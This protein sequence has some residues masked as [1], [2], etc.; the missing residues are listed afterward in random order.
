MSEFVTRDVEVQALPLG[1]VSLLHPER[2]VISFGGNTLDIGALCYRRLSNARRKG[3][4]KSR[5]VDPCSLDRTRI[6]TVRR[7]INCIS[8]IARTSGMS[9]STVFT[10]TSI[11]IRFVDWCATVG[12]KGVFGTE[13]ETRNAFRAYVEHLRHRVST[14]VLN[15]HT[16]FAY[17][18]NVL[19]FLCAFLA[20]DDIAHGVRLLLKGNTSNPTLVPDEASQG[21]VLSLCQNFFSQF[22]THVH[23]HNT[24]PFKLLLPDYL[25]WADNS[26]WIF[27][28]NKLFLSP[29]KLR[30]RDNMKRGYWAV[31]YA[32]GR[33]ATLDEIGTKY[34]NIGNAKRSIRR[35]KQ[36]ITD[37]NRDPKHGHRREIAMF[38]H[39]AFVMLFIANT[40]MNWSEVRKLP[41]GKDYEVGDERQGFRA[42]KF[43]AKGKS[44]S[45]EIQT[46]FL[47]KF[48]R[49]LELRTYLVNGKK[50]DTLF[51]SLGLRAK[52]KPK[53]MRPEVLGTLV[54]TLRRIDPSLPRILSRQ[55]RAAKSDFL[56]T[57]TDPSTTALIL[58]NSEPT[59]LR[60]YA[61]GSESRAIAEMGQF[62]EKLTQVVLD[63][64]QALPANYTDS[65]LGK[66]MQYGSP[67]PSDATP[68]IAPDCR[69]SEGCLFCDKYIVHAD[70]RDIRKLM[71][72]RSCIYRTAHLSASAEH[73][74]SLFGEVLHRIE[75]ILGAIGGKS[76]DNALLVQRLQVEVENYGLLDPYWERK[77]QTLCSLGVVS[78]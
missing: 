48:K 14:D 72:C 45:F 2:C 17:Q 10:S 39:N 78:Q 42:I 63:A 19:T 32:E 35:V 8:L 74:Q 33:L 43:R 18:D 31:N 60:S 5:F 11:F 27:P 24:Y 25:G 62:Y 41:W 61:A 56:I 53:P 71:S 59:V 64:G 44:V 23:D 76:D 1:K 37:A 28:T 75:A 13:Q 67:V 51:L 26:L 66:C 38:S 36:L 77:M 50:C 15:S 73:F 46:G 49:Y 9:I 69:Q 29:Q 7:M 47:A 40:G 12:H 70:E 3:R 54:M 30:Q 58:Q 65:A 55:W 21:R 20:K 57:R 16:A 34:N 52:K 68:P 22:A 4:N 6:D